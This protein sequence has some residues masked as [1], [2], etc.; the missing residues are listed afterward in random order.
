MNPAQCRAAR[1]LL[2]WTQPHLANEAGVSPST[3]RDFES[4]KRK[5]IANNV[6]AIRVALEAAGITFL[7]KGEVSPG[8]GAALRHP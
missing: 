8:P 3:L 5:P 2:E 7:E 4:G 1:A 6:T